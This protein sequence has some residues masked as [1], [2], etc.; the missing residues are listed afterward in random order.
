MKKEEE[1]EERKGERK[2]RR[3]T[4]EGDRNSSSPDR[5]SYLIKTV[6]P[7]FT[8][9]GNFLFFLFF[10]ETSIFKIKRKATN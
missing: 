10:F 9:E 8:S 3:K 7:S 2:K 6:F 5:K 1:E 4:Y